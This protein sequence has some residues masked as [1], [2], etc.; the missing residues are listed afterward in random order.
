MTQSQIPPQVR[1]WS[2]G[3]GFANTAVLHAL[4]KTGVIEQ[5]R[6][7]A[8]TLPELA[9]ACN[10]NDDVLFRTLR[11]ATVIDIVTA[12]EG[13][14]T[15]TDLGRMLLKDVPGSLRMGSLLVGSRPWQAA[16]QNFTHALVTGENAFDSAMGAP[17]F[18]YLNEHP[19]VGQPYDQ[20]MTIVT[21]MTARAITAAYDFTPF[22]TVCDIGGGQGILLKGILQANPHLRGTLYDQGHVLQGHVLG[23]L[24][25]RVTVE[26]GNFFERVPAADLLM[27]KSVLHDWDND[28]CLVILGHCRQVMTPSSRL[29][30]IDQVIGSPAD[31][32]GAFYDLHMQV[33][34]RGRERTEE[35]FRTLLGKAGLK[36]QRIIPTPSPMKIVEVSL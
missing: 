2:L 34:L 8:K 19:E 5:M 28:R 23:D 10:L 35:E 16:W 21:T 6:E 1:I 26:A 15:L 14:Y 4:T 13:Q 12:E 31:L 30:I 29:L 20:W 18:D 36:L 17:F 11:F 7:G 25:D 9:Q 3:L 33:L 32:M 24:N 22:G 27:M